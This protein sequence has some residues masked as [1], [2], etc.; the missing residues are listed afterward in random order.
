M[1]AAIKYNLSH[2]TDFG[3]RDTRQTFWFYVLFLVLVETALSFAISIPLTG[4]MM[5]EAVVAATR[6]ASETEIQQ[7]MFENIG[8]MMRVSVWLSSVLTVAMMA[9]LAASF[10]RRLHDSGKTGWI[11]A[12][13]IALHLLA[14][15][16]T[17]T[18]IDDA[19]RLVVL[20]QTG[21]ADVVGVLQKKFAVQSLIAWVPVAIVI[22]FGAWP[23]TK[24][25]NR[26]GPKPLQE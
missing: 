19:V 2:L 12:V 24:G 11:T 14:L 10:T 22:V 4:Q 9:L 18:S 16:M 13:T 21:H 20:V 5:G 1:L 15:A 17:V 3:G 7:R 25:E 26:Y 8:R 23:G 6:G